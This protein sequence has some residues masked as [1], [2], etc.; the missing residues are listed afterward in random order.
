MGCD[1]R[2]RL[3]S[4]ALPERELTELARSVRSAL[5]EADRTLTRF[6]PDSEL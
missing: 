6:D 2:V 5:E 1:A 3:E 4:T